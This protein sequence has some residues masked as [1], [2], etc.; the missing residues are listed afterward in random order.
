MHTFTRGRFLQYGAAGGALLFV[1]W[2]ARTPSARAAMGGKLTKYV[3]PLPRVG[4]GIAVAQQMPADSNHYA[5]TQ[6]ETAR[7][8]IQ[9]CRRRRSGRTTTVTAAWTVRRARSEPWSPL[10]AARQ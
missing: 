10:R 5:F 6:V 9:T 4:A 2:A 1:P 3:Q 8:L 7:Q